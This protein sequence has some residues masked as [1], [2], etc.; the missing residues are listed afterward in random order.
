M[1]K[2]VKRDVIMVSFKNLVFVL[3]ISLA[4]P[5]TGFAQVNAPVEA[6]I[7]KGNATE[8]KVYF[9][10]SVDVIILNEEGVYSPSEAEKKLKTFFNA[11]KVTGFKPVHKGGGANGRPHYVIG[12][13]N[14][15]NGNFRLTYHYKVKNDKVLISQFH[16]E[17][18]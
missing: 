1:V 7:K 11:A 3:L 14:T 2:F 17:E 16:I 8:L 4:L 5:F 12:E 18:E 10:Q 15:I 13:L 6:A 9:A